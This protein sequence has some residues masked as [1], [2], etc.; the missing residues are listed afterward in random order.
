MPFPVDGAAAG[1]TEDMWEALQVLILN[2]FWRGER[3][4]VH[5]GNVVLAAEH[6]GIKTVIIR[7]KD[8][9]A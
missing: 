6:L 5:D 2:P 4:A 3:V 9:I 1:L 8:D 7:R